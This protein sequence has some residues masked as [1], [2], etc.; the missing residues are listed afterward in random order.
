M[1]EL[2]HFDDGTPAHWR[3]AVRVDY[4]RLGKAR[5]TPVGGVRVEGAVARTGI[6]AYA[7]SDGTTVREL[8]PPE[9]A[10]RADSLA[11]LRDAPV[12]IG[13]P[14][15]G[16]RMVSPET[17]RSDAVGHIS[18]EPRRDGDH[19]VAELAIQD[20]DAIRRVDAGELAELSAGY[21]VLIDPTPGT[22]N[23][24]RYDAVQRHRSYNHVAL[25]AKG[26][27]RAGSS[28]AL[29]IDGVDDV[30]IGL[31]SDEI[32]P[33]ATRG[34]DERADC[35]ETERIDGVDYKVGS[36]EWRQ[37]KGKQLAALEERAKTAE[38]RADAATAR[39]EVSEKEKAELGKQLAEASSLERL[40]ARANERASLI[41]A[42]RELLGPE[43]KL[44]GLSDRE[45]RIAALTKLDPETKLE[46]RTDEAVKI[47]F[48]AALKFAA[49]RTDATSPLSQARAAALPAPTQSTRIDARDLKPDL[50]AKWRR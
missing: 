43:A 33:P 8:L 3:Q 13:H 32:D 16:T 28:A 45:I 21:R 31:R 41:T 5:R 34:P 37:V 4:G 26:R 10:G 19:V 6:L 42:A 39:L 18:G 20:A 11:S 29:R 12:T 47:H 2:E 49:K 22:W 36:P 17:Y 38:A 35:M 44:D 27:A 1:H 40:D 46:G 48:E 30:A 23:G 7:R 14:D 24:E 50:A 15:A 9:E 25:L